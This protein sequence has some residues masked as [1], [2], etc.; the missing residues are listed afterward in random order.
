MKN[1]WQKLTSLCRRRYLI[2]Q[3][4]HEKVYLRTS[5]SKSE[6]KFVFHVLTHLLLSLNLWRSMLFGSIKVILPPYPRLIL[7]RRRKT[8]KVQQNHVTW[9]DYI[10]PWIVLIQASHNRALVV[11]TIVSIDKT[12]KQTDKWLRQIFLNLKIFVRCLLH[13]SSKCFRLWKEL[14]ASII[15]NPLN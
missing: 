3:K 8:K 7:S 14:E 1:S 4:V 6:P 5:T 10:R 2:L 13:H 9:I 12:I 11:K 15:R